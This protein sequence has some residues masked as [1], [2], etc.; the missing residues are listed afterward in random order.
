LAADLR[1][2]PDHPILSE[3]YHLARQ[4][5]LDQLSLAMK[6]S[7]RADVYMGR[8]EEPE[9]TNLREAFDVWTN[10]KH[11]AEEWWGF[12]RAM[13]RADLYHAFARMLLEFDQD[14]INQGEGS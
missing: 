1:E 2:L 7:M 11:A 14:H 9:A 4:M 10:R 5:M 6:H 3:S 12:R 8:A 13:R